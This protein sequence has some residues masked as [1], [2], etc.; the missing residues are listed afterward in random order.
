M[1]V[2]MEGMAELPEIKAELNPDDFH[3]ATGAPCGP[4]GPVSGAPC[5]PGGPGT[6][7]GVQGGVEQ[8]QE[9]GACQWVSLWGFSYIVVS[10]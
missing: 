4:G 8:G 5:G 2:H 3:S 10:I 1:T 6:P 9:Q 7:Q